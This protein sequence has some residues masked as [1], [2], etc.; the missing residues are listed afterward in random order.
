MHQRKANMKP[1]GLD[2]SVNIS[3]RSLIEFVSDCESTLQSK[4]EED[5]AFRFECLLEYLRNDFT[6]SKGLHFKP[7]VIGL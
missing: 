3:L 6:P 2:D 1:A 4:G 7:G 5:E